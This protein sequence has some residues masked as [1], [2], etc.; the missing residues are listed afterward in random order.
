[1]AGT[2]SVCVEQLV[3]SIFAH[4]QTFLSLGNVINPDNRPD[5]SWYFKQ[6]AEMDCLVCE[7]WCSHTSDFFFWEKPK[8]WPSVDPSVMRGGWA[9]VLGKSGFFWKN[10]W[11]IPQFSTNVWWWSCN[12]QKRVPISHWIMYMLFFSKTLLKLT[13]FFY[14]IAEVQFW[15]QKY[16]LTCLIKPRVNILKTEVFPVEEQEPFQLLEGRGGF[17]EV[18]DILSLKDYFPSPLCPTALPLFYNVMFISYPL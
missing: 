4:P 9:W 6:L 13:K 17:R 10:R 1:M 11:Y 18:D 15:R 5:I 8:A 16:R 12:R 7:L 2:L 14:C 3:E